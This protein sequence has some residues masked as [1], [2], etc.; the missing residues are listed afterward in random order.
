MACRIC[1][2]R[3]LYPYHT[4]L[5][6]MCNLCLALSALGGVALAE[7]PVPLINQPLVPDAIKPGVAGFALTVNGTGFVSGSVV[8]WNGSALVTTFVSASRLTASVPA[9]DIAK[10]STASVTVVSPGPGGGTS[11][12]VFFPI[13][14][15]LTNLAFGG[16]TFGAGSGPR[17]VATGDFNGDGKLDLVV[18]DPKSGDVSILLGIGNGAFRPTA[19][20]A[21]GQGASTQ[22]FQVTVGDFN[23][24]GKL[25]FVVSDYDDN[26][27][28]VF[29]GNGDGTFQAAVNYNVGTN[30]TSVA[31]ADL[32]G[33]GKLD[34]VV[35]NQ[36]CANGGGPCVTGTVSILLGN[37]DGTF[38]THVD[39]DAGLDP[40]WVAVGDVNG[41]GKLDLAVVDGQ[42]NSQTSAVL[43]LLGNG[44]GTFQ[45][46]VSYPLNT[47]AA[48]GVT[49]DFN[50]DG[51]LDLAVADNIGLVSI[52]LGNGD[53]TFQPRVDYSA[54]SFPW[55]GIG[56]GD[57]NGDGNVDLAVANSGSNTVSIFL[58]NSNGTFQPQVQTSTGP[59]PQGVGVGDFNR[60]GALDFAVPNYNGNT[61]SILLQ[62]TNVTL[63][64]T[65]LTFAAQVVGSASAAQ[66][67]TLTNTGA[68][69]LTISGITLTGTNATDFG[70]TNTCGSR[71]A[72]GAKCTISV[73]FKPT[74]TGP[75]A[76]AVTVT[77]NAVGS[78]LSVALSGTGV[79]SGPNA[80]LS[81]AKLIFATQLVG[82]SSAAQSVTLTNYGT[83][84][85]S[86]ISIVASGDFSASKTCGSSLAALASCTI[87]VTFSPTMI[88]SRT[89][90]LSI[91]DNAPGNPQTASLKGVGT[92]VKLNPSSLSFGTH[93]IGTSTNLP[94]T[95]TNIGSTTLSISGITITGT[96]A[97]DFS[98]ANDC[99]TSVAGGGSCT[100]TV[101]FKPTATG[102]RSADLSISDNGGGSPQLVSLSGVGASAKYRC[103]CG[104]PCT[105]YC[106]LI[107]KGCGCIPVS[108][109]TPVEETSSRIPCDANK[110]K[111]LTELR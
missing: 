67:F 56:I 101:T 72:I 93:T 44:N 62:A 47:N 70:Q 89:G 48:S 61:V 83:T 79:V 41:D 3:V 24:D 102:S 69:A 86:I 66:M 82:I 99:G 4:V 75:R 105:F 71:L 22:V 97:G 96:N 85:L 2:L 73:T 78:P 43:V 51:K 103:S 12:N 17:S 77:G 80:T 15:P 63:L 8:H 60:D 5:A 68:L 50:H 100:I 74:E 31:V 92:V 13:G 111:W 98:Q 58:G 10:A 87:S 21:V 107:R 53:G 19:S 95:L 94:T 42:G 39:V 104:G 18:P 57:F 110:G 14:L 106:H 25:D 40:N 64:P 9:S 26:Y 36:N 54:G 11:N 27:V 59:V 108:S 28:S 6:L 52:L 46:P 37:G 35:S 45:T 109:S 23:G 90:K 81:P 34:I 65:S 29:L 55:G 91:T 38:Q 32:N 33:D 30:P 49:A 76:A 16:A 20:Y 7:N 1:L 88:G 84:A